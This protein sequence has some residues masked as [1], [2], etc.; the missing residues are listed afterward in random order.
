[1]WEKGTLPKEL[2]IYNIFIPCIS[3]KH[4]EKKKKTSVFFYSKKLSKELQVTT[5]LSKI[6]E[7]IIYTR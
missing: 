1:M 6:K 2:K 5:F 3:L 4:Q 7:Q